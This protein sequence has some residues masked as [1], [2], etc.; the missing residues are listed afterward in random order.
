VTSAGRY[1]VTNVDG[2]A[3]PVTV[4]EYKEI[5]ASRL[6]D[7]APTLEEFRAHW[8]VPSERRD[9]I[10][11]LPDA[12]RSAAL[13]R[14]LEDMRDFDLYDVLAE[15]GYGLAPKT[16]IERS[17]AFSYKHASWLSGLPKG[18]SAVIRAIASQFALAGTDGLENPNI[19]Q[20]PEVSCAGGLAALKTMGN[21][22]D[23][24]I[25]TKKRMFAA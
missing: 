7:E 8:I 11:H 20:T 6:V 24:L 9:L 21:P 12:G 17:D 15:L 25:E 3:Y 16:R 5:L 14:D 2:K 23:V 4:E 1:I 10:S 19:F 18:S 22:S 13:V